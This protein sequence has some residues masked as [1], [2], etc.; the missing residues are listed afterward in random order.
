MGGDCIDYVSQPD[1]GMWSFS[2]GYS[3]N[4]VDYRMSLAW[5]SIISRGLWT[6]SRWC[7]WCAWCGRC[8]WCSHTWC[9]KC[10]CRGGIQCTVCSVSI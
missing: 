1:A 3:F 2:V 9:G 8:L 10:V 6:C 7:G 5:S 4:I